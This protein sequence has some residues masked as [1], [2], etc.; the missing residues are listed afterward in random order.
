MMQ[1]DDTTPG[2]PQPQNAA[3][4]ESPVWDVAQFEPLINL[5]RQAAAQRAIAP[6]VANEAIGSVQFALHCVREERWPRERAGRSED[7]LSETELERL[8]LLNRKLAEAEAWIRERVDQ[9]QRDY[10]RAGGVKQHRYSDEHYEDVEIEV[11]VTCTLRHDHPDFK[12]DGE[13]IVARLNW[14]GFEGIVQDPPRHN[15]N[16]FQFHPEHRLCKEH[17]CWLMH[18]LYDHQLRCDWDAVLSI[19]GIWIDVQL[20]QQREMTLPGWPKMA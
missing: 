10:Y 12:E 6:W 19:G 8:R 14:M 15:W 16:A 7:N 1:H 2:T 20:I 5:L 9:C 18:D 3:N 13:N 11:K 4:D 17:H